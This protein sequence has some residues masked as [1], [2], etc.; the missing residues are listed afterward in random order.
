MAQFILAVSGPDAELEIDFDALRAVGE[1]TGLR[2]KRLVNPTW[3]EF[4]AH[5]RRLRMDG[6]LPFLHMAFHMGPDGIEFADGLASPSDLSEVVSGVPILLLAGCRST[7]IADSL[8]NVAAVVTLLEQIDHH[9]ARDL[10]LLFWRGIGEGAYAQNA[11]DDATRKLPDVG[12]Y[13]HLSVNF[14]ARA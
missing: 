6:P 5:L 4:A 8:R 3:S 1:Q 2:F 7:A 13:A 9:A 14:L 11:Y 10:T 12:E